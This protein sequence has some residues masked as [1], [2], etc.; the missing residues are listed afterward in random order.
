MHNSVQ[1]SPC[2]SLHHALR[3]TR[4]LASFHQEY[5]RRLLHDD[6]EKLIKRQ[7]ESMVSEHGLTAEVR[8]SMVTTDG[9]FF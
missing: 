4:R 5:A 8:W 1:D 7:Y 3:V 2:I 9:S 6:L